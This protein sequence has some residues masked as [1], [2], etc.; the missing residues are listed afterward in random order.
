MAGVVFFGAA[1]AR[2]QIYGTDVTGNANSSTEAANGLINSSTNGTIGANGNTNSNS[3]S[4]SNQ[5]TSTNATTTGNV[6]VNLA[7]GSYQMGSGSGTFGSDSLASFRT[8]SGTSG[9]VTIDLNAGTYTNTATG[10]TGKLSSGTMTMMR[11]FLASQS[12][13]STSTNGQ[14]SGSAQSGADGSYQGT[15]PMINVAQGDVSSDVSASFTSDPGDVRSQNDLQSYV[16]YT[17]S[18]DSNVDEVAIDQNGMD[19][20]YR[21]PGRFLGFIPTTV[22]VNV[23]VDNSGSVTVDYP[24]HSFMTK[25]PSRS[26]LQPVI[27]AR[28]DAVLAT[29]KNNAVKNMNASAGVS[30][31]ASA[32]VQGTLINNMDGEEALNYVS[33]STKAEI[34]ASI[35]AAMQANTTM[36]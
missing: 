9:S 24:W 18:N 19:I 5:S 2:A 15:Q 32:T 13:N 27:Q 6:T 25:K 22:R 3:D 14:A 36:Y 20:S 16:N 1:S 17:V 31:S 28:V 11:N 12:S 21:E 7:T 10:K 29:A 8:D 30:G 35:Q 26:E 4:N 23:H 34:I 33:S